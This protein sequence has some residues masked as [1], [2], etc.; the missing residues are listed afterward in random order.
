MTC[1]ESPARDRAE[2][3]ILRGHLCE[4]LGKVTRQTACPRLSKITDREQ[5]DRPGSKSCEAIACPPKVPPG[6][7]A[8]RAGAVEGFCWLLTGQVQCPGFSGK[9]YQVARWRPLKPHACSR[10]LIREAETNNPRI[11]QET[12]Q[13][14][15]A[16]QRRHA[17]SPWILFTISGKL[18][19]QRGIEP[20]TSS[21]RTTRSPN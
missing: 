10:R 12:G 20:L 2:D 6:A 14:R 16:G 21:L 4:L 15:R 13:N 18:V 17:S 19:E 1:G 9:R 5:K 3:G 8:D 7:V 11:H